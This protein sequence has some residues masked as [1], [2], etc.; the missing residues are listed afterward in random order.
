MSARNLRKQSIIRLVSGLVLLCAINVLAGYY[1]IRLDL[2]AEQRHSISASSKRLAGKLGDV[3]YVKV[4]L[5]GDLPPGFKRLR[6]ATRE[7]LDEFRLYAGDN[8]EYTFIDPAAGKGEKERLELY[9]QLAK[10]G[11]FPTNLEV[12]EEG[13]KSEK[14]IFPG[15]L[16]TYGNAEVPLQLLK[17]QMGSSPE[18]MLNNSVEGLEYE[19]ASAIRRLTQPIAKHIAFLRGHGEADNEHITDAARALS[20]YYKVDTL[21]MAEQ[22][23]SL[24]GFD[25]VIVAKPT[26][27][28]SEKDKFILDQYIMKG[29]KLLW[30]LDGMSVDMDSLT[31]NSTT[32]AMP[33]QLN[34][35]DQLFRYGARVNSDL[36]MDLQAA[37]I[38]VVTGYTGNA[39]RQELFPWPYFPLTQPL[40]NHPV[41][42]NLNLVKS[43]FGSS[44]DTIDVT[45]IQKTVLLTTSDYAR[46]QMP[47]ARVSLNILQ[48][49]PDKRQ[50][51]KRG[52][53][54]AVLLEGRFP[55][56]FKNRIPDAIRDS[57][58]I[59]FRETGEPTRMIV[60]GDGDVITNYVSRKGAIYPLGYD[61]F[62]Q[63]S[64]GNRNFILNCIDYLCDDSG[65]IELR[66]KEIRLRLLDKA[67]LAD[68]GWI[69]WTNVLAP[70]VL[71]VLA[72][73]IHHR[74]RR[75]KY[76]RK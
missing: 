69:R 43:E 25:A 72:G 60:V 67:K 20:E 42:N 55:S 47:P 76:S 19:I 70:L 22:L 12:Q 36:L 13:K 18:E 21:L 11:L 27:P 8:L 48:Q 39:P 4:Y 51:N 71:L 28:F 10:K 3:V 75:R 58:E 63:Q 66:G 33:S 29:G 40:G 53:P 46:I 65:V 41:V 74:V 31:Q 23:G 59:G 57:K 32:I 24:E 17:S 49:E 68:G 54:F 30:L 15:A 35:E 56:N 9:K 45:G 50:Y 14:I 52:L 16:V 5:D 26:A 62:T 1:F 61:R 34:L 7:M 44:V 6:N 2:T 38:P 37:P 73:T 64:Y